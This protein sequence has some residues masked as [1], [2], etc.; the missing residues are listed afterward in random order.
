MSRGEE[1]RR[2]S[3]AH[4][5][6][7]GWRRLVSFLGG[8]EERWETL[9]PLAVL[10]GI[11]SGLL[12]VGLRSSVHALYTALAPLRA[13]ILTG[14]ILPAAGAAAGVWIVARLF[15]EPPGHGVPD[16]I[17]AVCRQGGR[18]R[19]RSVFSRFFGSLVNVSAGGSAGLEGPIV[20][21][22][23]AVGSA[24]AGFFR[25][26][27]RRRSVLLACGV[28]GGISGVFNA[29]LTGMVFAT[30]VVLAEWSAF[31]I[32]PVVVAAVAGAEVSRLLLG[33]EQSFLH[34]PFA[35]GAWDLVACAALGAVAGLVS[36]ALQRAIHFCQ[37]GSASVFKGRMLA[38]GAC[39][40]GVGLVGLLAPLAIGEGYEGVQLAIHGE[41]RHGFFLAL[42]LVA[43]KLVT[44]ALTLGSGAPGGIFAPS[45]VLG[46][47]LGASFS[48]A[49]HALFPAEALGSEGSYALVGMAGLVAG[50]MQ[51][52]LTGIFL[53]LEVTRAFEVIPPLMVVAVVSLLVARRFEAYSLYTLELA[54]G[55]ELLRRGTDRRIL[56]DVLLR[57]TLDADAVP[58]SEDMT[59]AEFLQ[60]AR[61]TRRN[62]F[63]VLRDGS[64]ELAG[65]LD[66]GAVREL[67][68]DPELARLTLVGTVMETD[69]PTV[70]LD[71]N[72]ADALEVFERTG[73]WV[74]PVVEG[75]KFKGLLSK[76]TLFDRYRKELTVQTS[77]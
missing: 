11:A 44:T 16:V 72:L 35:M 68:L 31:S 34:A 9:L 62:H 19:R 15:R 69:V 42:A 61:H 4:S 21:S 65:M 3:L 77:V 5:F 55:G 23:A 36:T 50:V 26:D 22:A 49:V 43:A 54:Q 41:L 67:L 13:S 37:H 53:V 12:A 17:R 39:G 75:R 32:P 7:P 40:L 8:P 30:E 29:P 47:F 73:A 76:S 59:L 20:F 63:P 58:V 51:A 46:S 56:A 1:R 48:R 2:A 64:S 27:E 74:L 14:T 52:P 66:F 71:A 24:I 28:A 57:E 45:L 70:P 38:A 33:N 18:M 10:I 60:V 6:G 25:A